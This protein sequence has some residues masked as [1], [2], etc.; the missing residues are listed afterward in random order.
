ML[1]AKITRVLPDVPLPQYH[2]S[3]AAAFDLSAIESAVFAPGEV[4]KLP[5][6]LIIE[7]PPGHF[8]LLAPRSGLGPKRGL[9]MV[10]GVGI[11]DRDYAGP[12]DQI[13]MA[14]R[15]FTDHEVVVDKGERLVQG[16]FLPIQ[17]VEWEEVARIRDTNRGG[18][19]S[20]GGY[21]KNT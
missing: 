6:G 16:I 18:F 2:S 4:K 3:E 14:L 8:L 12:E 17:Q 21:Q 9:H 19:G 20:T 11:I 13:H 10:N 5:T 15:N 1:Q 7:A